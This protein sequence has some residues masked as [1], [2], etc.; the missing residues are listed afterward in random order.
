VTREQRREQSSDRCRVIWFC[1]A[2]AVGKSVVGWEAYSQLTAAGTPA[3][4]VDL[5]HLGF[6]SPQPDDLTGLVA[7]NLGLVWGSFARH[8]L[9]FLVVSGIVATTDDRRRFSERLGCELDLVLLRAR[10]ITIEERIVRRRQVEAQQQGSSLT[11]AVLAEL[12]AYAARS[13]RFGETLDRAG[14]AD[15]RLDTDEQ[16]PTEV[17]TRALDWAGTAGLLGRG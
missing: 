6:C 10:P 2:D 8:G 12:A 15:L 13:V 11:D 9:H 4:Y 14:F 1:G 16:T 7:E 5:D 17:A 3:A